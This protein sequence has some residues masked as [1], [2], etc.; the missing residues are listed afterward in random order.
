MNDYFWQIMVTKQ[1]H[2]LSAMLLQ[3]CEYEERGRVP[4]HTLNDFL[5]SNNIHPLELT[6]SDPDIQPY[7]T[8]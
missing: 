3:C 1:T 7:K 2:P 4:Q 5:K 6:S 8:K